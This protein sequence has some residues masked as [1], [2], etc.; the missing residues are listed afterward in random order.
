LA[1]GSIKPERRGG[2]ANIC[3]RKKGV[4][5]GY[6]TGAEGSPVR[7]GW[8]RRGGTKNDSLFERQQSRPKRHGA[9]SPELIGG[10]NKLQLMSVRIIAV[11]KV[12]VVEKSFAQ[13]A[14]YDTPALSPFKSAPEVT[15]KGKGREKQDG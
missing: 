14:M 15:K 12:G 7:S 11:H 1:S 5:E 2:L 10:G 8:D 4:R 9:G 13:A 3:I 6:R